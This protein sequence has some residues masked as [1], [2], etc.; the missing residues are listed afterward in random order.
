MHKVT[1]LA[2]VGAAMEPGPEGS[3]DGTRLLSGGWDGALRVLSTA[4]QPARGQIGDSLRG[5][6]G[7]VF[8]LAIDTAG[9]SVFAA[10]EQGTIA[11][12]SLRGQTALQ[13]AAL[14]ARA[15]AETVAVLNRPPAGTVPVAPSTSPS[16]AVRA[17][18]PGGSAA[19]A[20]AATDG[21]GSVFMFTRVTHCRP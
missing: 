4:G 3:P 17:S 21:A 6:F 12:F 8:A 13:V 10:G 5:T 19:T 15:P 2:F 1:S 7:A 9:G 11:R 14:P 16:P 18:A 20:A